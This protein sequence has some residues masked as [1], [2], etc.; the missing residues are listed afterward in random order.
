MTRTGPAWDA[1]RRHYDSARTMQLRELFEADPR[2]GS[3]LTVEHDGVYL[4]YSK[5]RVTP[6]SIGLLIALAESAGLRGGIDA[7]FAGEPINFTEHRPALHTVLRQPAGAAVYVDGSDVMPAV[8]RVLDRM[9]EFADQVR[10]G[11]WRG[12]TGQRIRTVVNI[13]IGGSDLG[14]AMAYRALPGFADRDL[15][16]R[17][18][19][20]IDGNDILTALRGLD[21]H[22]TLFV[23]SSKTFTTV[24]TLTNARTARSWLLDAT[25]DEASVRSHFVAV[26]TNAEQ[27]AAFGIEPANMFEFWDWVGGR[28]SI[29]SAI[30]LAL[31]IGVGPQSFRDM[32]AGARS[33]DEHFRS[34]PFER[35]I[36][37]LLGLLGVWN[38]NF[39]GAQ[40]HAVIPYDARLAS[41]PAYLQ[42]LEMES[43]GK[44]V[45]REG[46]AVDVD[47]SPIVWGAPGTNG[48]HAF[49]QLLHQGTTVVPI[50]FIGVLDPGHGLHLHHDLLIAN[51]LAQSRA[52]A[53]GDSTAPTR[54]PEGRG[55]EQ[56]PHRAFAGN[57]PSST[58][59]IP[60]LTPF[61]LGQLIA[62]YEHKVFTQGYVWGINPFDQWGVEL[63][64]V[65]ATGIFDELHAD[66]VGSDSG[67]DS[68]TNEL[69]GRYRAVRSERKQI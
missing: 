57:R 30:G 24:E 36:P 28:Y 62:L 12:Y 48:Q 65:V 66:N 10:G 8:H 68:S 60:D 32:L 31:M 4:D 46:N 45:D 56:S 40:T 67:W 1:L 18:V 49:F 2:R 47:T 55:Q 39:L 13:G 53:F 20:N 69:I 37:V 34:A 64:K 6:E 7:L 16:V 21:P 58:I 9:G 41:F 17:F 52:L 29:H 59:L 51:L 23:V 14:P 3:A 5:Q 15:D 35:N 19:S 61:S 43:N 42:Q 54:G 50:D 63:G 25:G 11:Q 44:S 38:R 33:M 27:V 26:S 22:E